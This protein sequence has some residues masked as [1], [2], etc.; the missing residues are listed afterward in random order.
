MR[1]RKLT[2][3]KFSVGPL[4]FQ[5]SAIVYVIL[6]LESKFYPWCE[7]MKRGAAA[8]SS[9][10]RKGVTTAQMSRLKSKLLAQGGFFSQIALKLDRKLSRLKTPSGLAA[11]SNV[12]PAVQGGNNAAMSQTP[13]VQQASQSATGSSSSEG[14]EDA[15]FLKG[16]HRE[17]VYFG[18]VDS[19]QVQACWDFGFNDYYVDKC[20]QRI[21]NDALVK[22]DVVL[23]P[24]VVTD[25][26]FLPAD[27]MDDVE[28]G[29]DD[30]DAVNAFREGLDEYMPEEIEIPSVLNSPLV[31]EERKQLQ[32]DIL[33][34]FLTVGY[35][36]IGIPTRFDDEAYKA[37]LLSA[38]RA[39]ERRE[40]VLQG[41]MFDT[42][43]KNVFPCYFIPPTYGRVKGY[44]C[45]QS[46][47]AHW[48]FVPSS[49]LAKFYV[50]NKFRFEVLLPTGGLRNYAPCPEH[51]VNDMLPIRTPLVKL[52]EKYYNLALYEGMHNT[53][54]SYSAMP[55][56]VV[57]PELQE[58]PLS[59]LSSEE[60]TRLAQAQLNAT[61]LGNA[62]SYQGNSEYMDMSATTL[63]GSMVKMPLATAAAV[64][65]AGQSM[66]LN[67]TWKKTR[68]TN[69]AAYYAPSHVNHPS[70]TG[71]PVNAEL[72]PT[73]RDIISER[74]KTSSDYNYRW[75]KQMLAQSMNP[76][77]NPDLMFRKN[78]ALMEPNMNLAH[79]SMPQYLGVPLPEMQAMY[80]DMVFSA[81]NM[82]RLMFG[83]AGG[84]VNALVPKKSSGGGGGGGGGGGSKGDQKTDPQE[85]ALNM[86]Q[87]TY[88][89]FVE[90]VQRELSVGMQRLFKHCVAPLDGV[91][92]SKIFDRQLRVAKMQHD[93]IID[94]IELFEH[95]RRVPTKTDA[96][97]EDV[98]RELEEDEEED[99]DDNDSDAMPSIQ[100]YKAKKREL[101]KFLRERVPMSYD[102]YIRITQYLTFLAVAIHGNAFLTVEY[103]ARSKSSSKSSL[104]AGSGGAGAGP[105]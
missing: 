19:L 34:S 85:I 24:V 20:I 95:L 23:K 55:F 76:E 101:R 4:Y 3:L 5:N 75:I 9:R 82:T 94:A 70:I 72:D 42:Y 7:N 45:K 83:L 10:K 44:M 61:Y 29:A 14:Q 36:V 80:E 26:S 69:S 92:L 58:K 88:D 16:K 27:V 52:L 46:F 97:A 54:C 12:G 25:P 31:L 48:R 40:G 2:H 50:D 66:Q 64:I 102:A 37:L 47:K 11:Y 18:T 33:R 39:S 21:Q 98:Q 84:R 8:P 13:G 41:A 96:M 17:D 77:L 103:V 87:S 73:P 43:A 90:Q 6:D 57:Q 93:T 71:Q 81:F 86:E 68:T 32:L 1:R 28:T 62:Q 38:K 53:V 89:A 100:S 35:A 15:E 22:Y 60:R 99:D 74:S 51:V 65:E 30:T 105:L 59:E 63:P 49:P 67:R 79:A 104:P 56:F 91:A 78:R